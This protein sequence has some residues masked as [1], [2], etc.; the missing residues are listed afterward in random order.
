MAGVNVV[1]ADRYINKMKDMI[2]RQFSPDVISEID[3]Y[4]S[5]FTLD[6][7]KYKCP[8]LVS[9]TDGVGTKLKVRLSANLLS[10]S[11]YRAYKFLFLV[12]VCTAFYIN[13]LFL[14]SLLKVYKYEKYQ[15]LKSRS[16]HSHKYIFMHYPKKKGFIKKKKNWMIA[17]WGKVNSVLKMERARSDVICVH[18][19]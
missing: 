4:A 11:I 5:I 18:N 16:A 15:F 19:C 8:Y 10:S 7:S 1:E 2:E 13:S 12:F 3:S 14:S 9:S 6:M 17:M